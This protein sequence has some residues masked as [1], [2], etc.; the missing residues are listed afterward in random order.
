[1][2]P[3]CLFICST[4]YHVLIA[5][6][7]TL[8]LNL[9]ADILLMS[10]IPDYNGLAQKLTKSGVF[11]NVSVFARSKTNQ[12]R[13]RN[14]WDRLLHQHKRNPRVIERKLKIDVKRYETVYIFNDDIELG[15]YLQDIKC[16]Y[17]LLEDACDFMKIIDK[18]IF[19]PLLPKRGFKAGLKKMFNYGYFPLG[20]NKWA[21]QIEVNCKEG[22]L[23]PDKKVVEAPKAELFAKLTPEQ[24]DIIYNIFCDKLN[25]TVT[26]ARKKALLLTQPISF[27]KQVADDNAQ[28]AVF[29]SIIDELV[30]EGFMVYLKPHPRDTV[31]YAPIRHCEAVID[32]NIPAEVL[33]YKRDIH[34]NRAVT[35][36][37]TAIYSLDIAEEKVALG[38]E[39]LD[40]F[41]N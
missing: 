21:T 36:N 11:V 25:L 41:N 9:K 39:Y 20:Q 5:I 27:E 2:E 19:A 30:E 32:K 31:S 14:A 8:V 17:V 29:Q 1:M 22:I 33:N 18:T 3:K 34:F 37:S 13:A 16:R 10:Y 28:I 38:M 23:I 40:K 4:Y 35:L 12:Y 7:K 6:V 26:S 24:S 15:H